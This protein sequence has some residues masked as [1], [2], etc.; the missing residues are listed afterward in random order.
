MQNVVR[1]DRYGT[2]IIVQQGEVVT[3]R[4]WRSVLEGKVFIVTNTLGSWS[5]LGGEGHHASTIEGEAGGIDQIRSF[6][7][8]SSVPFR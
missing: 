8:I 3:Q 6:F 7:F 2:G 5:L 4:A 1:S